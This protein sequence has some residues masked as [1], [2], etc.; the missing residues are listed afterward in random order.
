MKQQINELTRAALMLA[1]LLGLAWLPPVPIGIIPVPIVVQNLA[2]ML[3]GWLLP[4]RKTAVVMGSFFLL[5]ALGLPVLPGGRGGLS[6]LLSPSGA[7]LLWWFVGPLLVSWWRQ[8]YGLPQRNWQ[9]LLVTWLTTAVLIDFGGAV[10]LS[11]AFRVPWIASLSSSLVF[12][13]GDTIKAIVA[14]AMVVALKRTRVMKW[15]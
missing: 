15:T 13:V 10:V 8:F 1:V 11:L 9:L 14:T 6:I 12:L 5:A 2:V 4:W 3:M 7:Y